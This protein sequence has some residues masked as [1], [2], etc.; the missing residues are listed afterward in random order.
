MVKTTKEMLKS[1]VLKRLG[2]NPHPEVEVK[3]HGVDKDGIL[4][5]DIYLGKVSYVY[6]I[7]C[8]LK[9]VNGDWVLDKS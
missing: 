3:C 1:A 6:E 4:H 8:K 7:D 9:L 2:N 5:M